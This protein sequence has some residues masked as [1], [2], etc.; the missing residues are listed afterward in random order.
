LGKAYTYL[1]E[2]RCVKMFDYNYLYGIAGLIVFIMDVIAIVEVIGS[3]RPLL[4]KAAWTLFIIIFPVFGLIVYLC[5]G[6]K[7]GYTEI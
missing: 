6:R 7:T 4:H 5:C 2:S 3:S 1:S